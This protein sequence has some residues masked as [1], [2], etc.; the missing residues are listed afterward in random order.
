MGK[1]KPEAVVGKVIA[2]L[3]GRGG[4]G[5]GWGSKRGHP[6]LKPVLA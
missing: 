2:R 1:G 6:I 3:K 4:L 5:L